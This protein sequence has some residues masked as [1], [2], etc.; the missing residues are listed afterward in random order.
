MNCNHVR[1][2]EYN[3]LQD[4]IMT[5]KNG[6]VKY[7]I[8]NFLPEK[9]SELIQI[10]ITE[11]CFNRWGKELGLTFERTRSL[12]ESDI[13]IFWFTK[14]V[15]SIVSYDGFDGLHGTLARALIT[16]PDNKNY[17][18]HIHFDVEENWTTSEIPPS[19]GT[20]YESVLM[21]EIGHILGLAHSEVKESIM[22]PSYKYG[23]ELTQDDID[24]C[25]ALRLKYKTFKVDI[26]GIQRMINQAGDILH[27]VHNQLNN[28]KGN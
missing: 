23:R 5:Q 13:K 19:L 26:Q 4:Y 7:H 9:I 28:L 27:N 20:D 11:R 6:V 10:P 24:A 1:T 18:G 21:H 3:L 22:F 12:D 2:E 8:F 16:T 15:E 14:G 25:T 17:F